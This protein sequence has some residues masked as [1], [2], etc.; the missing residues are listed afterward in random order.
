MAYMCQYM[1]SKWNEYTIEIDIG[2]YPKGIEKIFPYVI[3]S[4]NPANV[5]KAVASLYDDLISNM[6][7]EMKPIKYLPIQQ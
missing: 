6:I 3:F 4:Q 1:R 2:I 5:M 7:D